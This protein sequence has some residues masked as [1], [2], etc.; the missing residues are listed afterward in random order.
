VNF[1][2]MSQTVDARLVIDAMHVGAR[3]FIPLPLEEEKFR[4]ALAR[5]AQSG[6]AEDVRAKVIN[7]IPMTGGCGSTTIA[8]NVA[9]ALS[10]KG[11]AALVDLD[12][13][14]GA[15]ATYFDIRPRFTI[16][17]VMRNIE[18]ID[19]QLVENALAVHAPT[20]LAV[21]ARPELPEDG[22]RVTA[23]GLGRLLGA[24]AHGYD[25]VVLDSA[26]G[27]DPVHAAAARMA[28]VN[29][30]VVEQNVPSAK[31]AERFMGA[32]ARMKVDGGRVRVVVNRHLRRGADV[33]LGDL[34]RALKV[35]VGWT[36]PNDFRNALAAI[37]VGEPVLL[38]APRAEIS[39]S[40]CQ[41][42]SD[43][44]GRSSEQGS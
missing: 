29:V 30:L 25:Y 39:S 34:E 24:M 21:L 44:N 43:L 20:G 12:L 40:L 36:V 38:R 19:R 31:N 13:V 23:E 35:K 11:K 33:E 2:V 17:D 16:A 22:H 32:L 14:R 41:L 15:V 10:R 26:M 4:Q 7:V 37:N 18:K 3:E 8:C 9:T 1:F 27:V 6:G 42:A 5:A 28:D